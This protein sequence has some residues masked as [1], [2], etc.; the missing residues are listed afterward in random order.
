MTTVI[1]DALSTIDATGDETTPSGASGSKDQ[2][3]DFE[4]TIPRGEL[5]PP[6]PAPIVPALVA[7]AL[8]PRSLVRRAEAH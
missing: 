6:D 4:D 1:V 5:S 8:Y 2:Y 7:T 3:A